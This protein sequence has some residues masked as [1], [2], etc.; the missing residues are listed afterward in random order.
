MH[1]DTN[2]FEQISYEHWCVLISSYPCLH[3]TF[4]GGLHLVEVGVDASQEMIRW[5]SQWRAREAGLGE[6]L[7]ARAQDGHVRNHGE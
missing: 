5:I 3:G 2:K 6:E 7:Q 1:R 4:Q